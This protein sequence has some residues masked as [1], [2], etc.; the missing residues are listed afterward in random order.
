MGMQVPKPTS[1][2]QQELGN[3]WKR[4]LSNSFKVVRIHLPSDLFDASSEILT[5]EEDDGC[6]DCFG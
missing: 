5:E 4:G 2:R 3:D 1:V 6:D